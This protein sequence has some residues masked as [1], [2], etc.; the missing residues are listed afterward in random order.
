[1][2]TNL[3]HG[4]KGREVFPDGWVLVS[5]PFQW[6]PT[7]TRNLNEMDWVPPAYNMG[8]EKFLQER[9]RLLDEIIREFNASQ[10]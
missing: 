4:M 8:R 7:V 9:D 2:N 10:Q 5:I 1:M 6:I 3:S